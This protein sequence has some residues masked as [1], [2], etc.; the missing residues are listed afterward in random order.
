M[1]RRAGSK[2]DAFPVW[3]LP[4]A[5]GAPNFMWGVPTTI[6]GHFHQK[7]PRCNLDPDF[8]FLRVGLPFAGKRWVV[9]QK[10]MNPK[11]F[12]APKYLDPEGSE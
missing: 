10:F 7:V 2:I 11:I 8:D 6:E 9:E 3:A 5:R 1:S 4:V 12:L